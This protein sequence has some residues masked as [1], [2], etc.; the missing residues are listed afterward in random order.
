MKNKESQ[1]KQLINYT[2][3]KM[4]ILGKNAIFEC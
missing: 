2:T 1:H 4:I 3:K